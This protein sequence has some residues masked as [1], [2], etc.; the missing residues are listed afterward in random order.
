LQPLPVKAVEWASRNFHVSG[1]L[2]Y[3]ATGRKDDHNTLTQLLS[4]ARIRI[5]SEAGELDAGE[6]LLCEAEDHLAG[7][8]WAS[9]SHAACVRSLLATKRGS[10]HDAIAHLEQARAELFQHYRDE[11]QPHVA[12]CDLRLSALDDKKVTAV[13]VRDAR[14]A[15]LPSPLKFVGV[16][17]LDL[18]CSGRSPVAR[19]AEAIPRL[20]PSGSQSG[21]RG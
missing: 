3:G 19:I 20:L 7:A 12:A 15:V 11:R 8:G 2:H 21:H 16:I 18:V 17:D 10:Q 5:Q 4:R 14:Q 13:R 1:C 6:A 9:R